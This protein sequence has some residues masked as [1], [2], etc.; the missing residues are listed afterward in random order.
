VNPMV[1]TERKSPWRPSVVFAACFYLGN[2][3]CWHIGRPPNG[4][5]FQTKMRPVRRIEPSD[6]EFPTFAL[7]HICPTMRV[8]VYSVRLRAVFIKGVFAFA[9]IRLRLIDVLQS[10][11]RTMQDHI[12][13]LI[14]FNCFIHNPH[15][16]SHVI[17]QH[18]AMTAAAKITSFTISRASS[19]IPMRK[20]P[21][22][23]IPVNLNDPAHRY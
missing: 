22:V 9:H 1:L 19:V 20:R 18:A 21:V 12:Y 11:I 6:F 2:A 10:A 14:S 8:V 4:F 15:F 23:P 5:T 17:S 3:I 16:P 13:R 7:M